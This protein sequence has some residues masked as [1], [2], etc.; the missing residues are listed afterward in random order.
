MSSVELESQHNHK[1][2]DLEEAFVLQ[3]NDTD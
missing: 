1:L 2:N 3:W